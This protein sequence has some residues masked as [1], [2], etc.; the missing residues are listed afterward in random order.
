MHGRTGRLRAGADSVV[1][2][3][4]TGGRRRLFTIGTAFVFDARKQAAVATSRLVGGT[5][6]PEDIGGKD[7]RSLGPGG[8]RPDADIPPDHVEPAPGSDLGDPADLDTDEE[9]PDAYPSRP[10]RS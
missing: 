8:G 3:C 5:P 9:G 6:A 7:G 1:V 2:A 4:P 10:G